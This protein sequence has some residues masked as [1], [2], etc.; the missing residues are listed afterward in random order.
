MSHRLAEISDGSASALVQRCTMFFLGARF[1]REILKK[2]RR[3]NIR[4]PAGFILA[5]LQ[6][7]YRTRTIIKCLSDGGTGNMFFGHSDMQIGHD[8]ARKIGIAHYTA[9]MAAVV[10]Q[11]KN[12]YVQHDVMV[13][14]YLGGL[15]T[16]FWTPT[17]YRSFARSNQT[18]PDASICCFI[19]PY[20]ERDIPMFFDVSGR[21]YT[22]MRSGIADQR[23]GSE[24]AFSTA[25]MYNELY[26]FYDPLARTR[27]MDQPDQ[28]HGRKHLNRIVWRGCQYNKNPISGAFDKMRVN[29]GHQGPSV[30]PGCGQVRNGKVA[31]L[32]PKRVLA[33]TGN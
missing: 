22:Q 29:H 16:R 3:N 4:I 1:N 28:R 24:L 18:S 17:T 10:H 8:T 30:Y 2:F 12:V 33:S 5:R 15:G 21:F 6:A 9:Y 23:Q 13:C 11:P 14:G 31:Y 25:L 27:S 20:E 7:T 32:D 19:I 26:G